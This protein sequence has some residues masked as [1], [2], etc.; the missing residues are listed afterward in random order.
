MPSRDTYGSQPPLELLRQWL[1]HVNWYDLD[2]VSRID[3]VDTY[4]NMAMGVIGGS[5]FIYPRL[6]RHSFVLSVDSF[7]NFTLTHIFASIAH[8]HFS[9][10]FDSEVSQW[11]K[12]LASAMSYVYLRAMNCFLPTPE[13]MHYAFS[14]RDMTRIF[15]GIVR[16]PSHRLADRNKLIRLW[17]HETYRIFHDRLIDD[18]D[19]NLLLELVSEATYDNFRVHLDEALEDWLPAPD[20]AQQ[21]QSTVTNDVISNII[22]GNFIDEKDTVY[23]EISDF[24]VM[25]I[26]VSAHLARYNA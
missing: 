17:I 26:A 7:E 5:N 3:I 15:Q 2:D 25:E 14:L 8:W 6:Y 9:N 16:V 11:T 20:D 10:G 18:S 22:Y 12:A 1:D 4:V 13:K 24:N 21:K 23:D 19:R